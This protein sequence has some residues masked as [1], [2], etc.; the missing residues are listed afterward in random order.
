MGSVGVIGSGAW[1]TTLALLLARKGIATVLWEH[2]P[3]RALDMQRER[4]NALFLPGIFFPAGLTITSHLAE[5]TRDKDMLM[6]VTPSQRM[7]ENARLLK[8]FVSQETLLV[9]AS[10]GIEIGMLKRMT[11]MIA[12]ELPGH[13][14]QWWL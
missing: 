14:E 8:P 7:R 9:S 1:G 6:L 5:A 12:E 4:E 13:R 3:E 10:K 11:E 2:H